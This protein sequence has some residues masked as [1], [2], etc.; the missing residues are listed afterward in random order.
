MLCVLFFFFF[1]FLFFFFFFL[2][3]EADA[4]EVHGTRRIFRAI[5]WEHPSP[6][7]FPPPPL[8]SSPP[9]PF[10]QMVIRI[11]WRRSCFLSLPPSSFSPSPYGKVILGWFLLNSLLPFFSPPFPLPWWYARR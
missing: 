4:E 1:F 8:F 11:D 2:V 9:S 5:V 6:S 7:L 10:F 3:V